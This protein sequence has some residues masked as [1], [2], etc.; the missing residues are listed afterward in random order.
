MYV[1]YFC[2]DPVILHNDPQCKTHKL[3]KQVQDTQDQMS[4]SSSHCNDRASTALQFQDGLTRP[5]GNVLI[6]AKRKKAAHNAVTTCWLQKDSDV[7]VP[8]FVIYQHKLTDQMPGTWK[9]F[10]L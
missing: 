8:D 6:G 10:I 3:A 7:R 9:L 1:D 5:T 2:E 4:K